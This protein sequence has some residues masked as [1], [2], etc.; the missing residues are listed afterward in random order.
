MWT[1]NEPET[2]CHYLVFAESLEEAREMVVARIRKVFSES[3]PDEFE[4]QAQIDAEAETAVNAF[5]HGN[6][7]YLET[8]ADIRPGVVCV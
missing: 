7:W 4:T 8:E 5:L 2:C 6:S 3:K 1:E